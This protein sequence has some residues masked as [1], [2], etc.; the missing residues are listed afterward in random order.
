MAFE[1]I[2]WYFVFIYYRAAIWT[3][4]FNYDP[5][6]ILSTLKIVIIFKESFIYYIHK[7]FRKTN[8]SYPWYPQVRV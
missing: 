2:I 6:G 4:T 3:F 7:I 8:T 1:A 5:A